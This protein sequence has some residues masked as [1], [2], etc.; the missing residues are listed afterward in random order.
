MIP[1]H[2]LIWLKFLLTVDVSFTLATN[3]RASDANIRLYPTAN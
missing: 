3:S 1:R 2:P